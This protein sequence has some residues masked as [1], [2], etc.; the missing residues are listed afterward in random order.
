[1]NRF[2]TD[3]IEPLARELRPKTI[4]EI[5]SDEGAGTEKLLRFCGQIGAHLHVVDPKP[6]YDAEVWR[7][8]WGE[9]LTY[10]LATSLSAL[11]SIGAVDLALI[12][13]DHNWYTVR[14]ELELLHAAAAKAGKAFPLVFLHDVGWPYGRRDLYY[15][16]DTVPPDQRRPYANGGL[17]P[18]WSA[19]IPGGGY[20][21]H[22]CNAAQEDTPRNGVLTAIEDF[23]ADHPDEDLALE[24]V[25]VLFGLGILYRRSDIGSPL[26]EHIEGVVLAPPAQAL[27]AIAESERIG[28]LIDNQ[29]LVLRSELLERRLEAAEASLVL[30]QTAMGQVSERLNRAR[31]EA[32][33]FKG[34]VAV[35]CAELDI[36]NTELMAAR[37]RVAALEEQWA[38]WE[39]SFSGRVVARLRQMSA[40]HPG[41][42]RGVR[43][44]MNIA[45]RGG[46][47]AFRSFGMRGHGP[48]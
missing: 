25:P 10:H 12:D 18:G 42:A 44:A 32:A 39:A 6:A 16:P 31:G 24:I 7:A 20:N 37:A 15:D 38:E 33:H 17:A 45:L 40:R 36:R 4:V 26:K 1:M 14:N 3:I 2:W 34:A 28:A 27:V 43:R 29:A 30:D 11:P 22:C 8:R 23:M 19:L 48:S 13:G 46:R 5:G 41:L 21:A 9:G 47:K 35:K